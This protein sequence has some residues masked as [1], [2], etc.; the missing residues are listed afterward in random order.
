MSDAT[1]PT[2]ASA[3]LPCVPGQP[4]VSL[5]PASLWPAIPVPSGSGAAQ[6]STDADNQLTLG[7]DQGLFVPRAQA[8]ADPLAYYILAKA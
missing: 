8:A 4:T 1:A 3:T 6:I 5:P 2:Q 7:T